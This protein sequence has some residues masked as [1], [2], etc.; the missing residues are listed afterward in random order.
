VK[1][2][3]PETRLEASG[4]EKLKKAPQNPEFREGG[5]RGTIAREAS[6]WPV[7]STLENSQSNPLQKPEAVP[8]YR[9]VWK[10]KGGPS[11]HPGRG[12][13]VESRREKGADKKRCAEKKKESSM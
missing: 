11:S 10:R 2:S 12:K 9:F 13:G 5:E 7:P 1:G 6:K 4:R 3:P 8:D